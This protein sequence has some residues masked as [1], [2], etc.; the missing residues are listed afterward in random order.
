MFC[1]ISYVPGTF[2]DSGDTGR[3]QTD[4]SPFIPGAGKGHPKDVWG[5]SIQAELRVY[6]LWAGSRAET[7]WP[8]MG[9]AQ[10]H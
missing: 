3:N 2:L 10:G 1:G 7:D 6:G 5:G 4:N 9:A 8:H